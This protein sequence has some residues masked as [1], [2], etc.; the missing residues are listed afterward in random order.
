[1]KRKDALNPDTVRDP[2][3][4][5]SLVETAPTPAYNHAFEYLRPLPASFNNLDVHAHGVAGAEIKYFFFK[6]SGE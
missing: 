2:P 1:M 6:I 3:D 4:R 5:E